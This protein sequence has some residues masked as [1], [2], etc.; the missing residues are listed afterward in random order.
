LT[1]FVGLTGLD[2]LARDSPLE[3]A[4]SEASIV[5]LARMRTVIEN[6]EPGRR[7]GFAAAISSCHDGFTLTPQPFAPVSTS[8]HTATVG[9]RL[10]Q[11]LGIPADAAVVGLARLTRAEFAYAQCDADE[12]SLPM[13][14]AVASVRLSSGEWLNAEVHPHEWH[15]GHLFERIAGYGAVCLL[16]GALAIALMHRLNRPLNDLT[17]AAQRFGNGLNA[18]TVPVTGPRDLREAIDAFNVMQ[19]RVAREVTHRNQTLAAISHDL[20]APLT[21]LRIKAE[22]VEDDV[23]R[24]DLVATIDRMERLVA[25][26]LEYLRGEARSEPIRNIDLGAMLASECSDFEEAGQTAV[27]AGVASFHYPCRPDALARAVRNLIENANKYAHGAMVGM[28]ASA[29]IVEIVVSDDGPGIPQESRTLALEPFWRLSVARE[30]DRGGFGL[31]LAV[32]DAI[33][34]GHDG[35]LVLSDNEPCGLVATIRLPRRS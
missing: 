24:A 15:P 27:Y 34:R 31:G 33:A 12:I 25:S 2:L 10:A 11:A 18:A 20:R 22:L 19:T 3:W 32:V 9:T 16:V 28:S 29:T 1:L 23:R 8:T 17:R 4:Q 13:D 35:E 14:A 7:A 21:A 5:R 30:S 6:I 26:A